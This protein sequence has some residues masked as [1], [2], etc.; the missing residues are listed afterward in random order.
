M[1]EKILSKRFDKIDISIIN[2]LNE[3]GRVSD[4]KLSDQLGIS[5]TTVRVRRLKLQKNG[6]IKITGLLVLQKMN[7]SYADVLLKFYPGS[8]IDEIERFIESC[9]KDEYVYEITRY[10]G[11]HDL[12]L[13]LFDEDFYN[14]KNHYYEVLKD[15]KIIKESKLI[16]VVKSDKAWG[17]IINYDKID[18]NQNGE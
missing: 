3:D 15:Q 5:K 11:D 18:E 12:L 17:Q 14:L 10:V 9:K 6:A 1:W 4:Q 8:R 7:L 13:R 16:P 2:S